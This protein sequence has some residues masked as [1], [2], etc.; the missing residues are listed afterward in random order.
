VNPMTKAKRWLELALHRA[1]RRGWQGQAGRIRQAQDD[2]RPPHRITWPGVAAA[3]DQSRLGGV[4][5][6]PDAPNPGTGWCLM[7]V[8]LCYGIPPK[9]ADATSAWVGAQHRHQ[10]SDPQAIPRGY[11]VFWLGGSSGHG[12]V[13]VSAGDGHCWSTDV[14]RPGM[15]DRVPIAFIRDHW[16]LQLVGWAEDLNGVKVDA[17]V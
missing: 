8:R 12:H 15:M 1:K 11:P 4:P 10:V 9:Y 6:N 13:A 5:G 16:G 7:F 3:R 17:H 2:L 14:K